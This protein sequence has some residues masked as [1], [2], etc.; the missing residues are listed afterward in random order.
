MANKQDYKLMLQKVLEVIYRDS[1]QNMFI[2][3]KYEENIF[4]AQEMLLND[5]PIYNWIIEYDG[6][7]R[8]FYSE[9][10]LLEFIKDSFDEDQNFF[11]QIERVYKVEV[12]EDGNDIE[13]EID[14]S[15]SW[16]V[17]IDLS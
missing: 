15:V 12:D 9:K 10:E 7:T 17:T 13:N 4:K 14:L 3:N 8:K 5:P 1:D 6:D 11:S 16:S 2:E